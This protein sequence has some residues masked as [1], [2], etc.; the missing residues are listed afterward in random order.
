MTQANLHDVHEALKTV[1]AERGQPAVRKLLNDVAGVNSAS[2][3]RENQFADVIAAC[4]G[5]TLALIKDGE[6]DSVAIWDRYN[7][8]GKRR[9]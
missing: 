4:G 8:S 9:A 1:K 3:L 5:K 2:E 7:T 6:L